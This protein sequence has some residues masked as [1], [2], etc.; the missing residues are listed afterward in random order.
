MNTKKKKNTRDKRN[1]QKPHNS[2]G[3]IACFHIRRE[4]TQILPIIL[5]ACG[6]WE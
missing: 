6:Y 5:E 1:L 4:D 3:A 2:A